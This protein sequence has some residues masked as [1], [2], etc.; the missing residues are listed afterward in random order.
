M[1]DF[2]KSDEELLRM[3]KRARE[4]EKEGKT[5]VWTMKRDPVKDYVHPTQ[6]PIEL[7]GYA[8]ANSSKAGDVVLDLFGGSGS[9]LIACEKHKRVARTMELDERYVEVIIKRFAQYTDGKAVIRC[10]NRALDI[11]AI[12]EANGK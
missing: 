7:I 3:L 5:T 9:T 10:V 12:I 6:K 4:A 1:V 8:L 2:Q 11:N